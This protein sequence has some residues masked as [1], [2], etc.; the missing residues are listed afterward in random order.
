MFIMIGQKKPGAQNCQI[1]EIYQ[2]E[3]SF[4]VLDKTD[5]IRIPQF[6]KLFFL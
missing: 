1:I 3:R 6:I 5:L 2:S 4:V